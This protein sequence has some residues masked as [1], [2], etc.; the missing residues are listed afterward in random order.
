[1][2]TN[3]IFANEKFDSK[4]AAKKFIEQNKMKLK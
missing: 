1:L 2:E 4:D 3:Q